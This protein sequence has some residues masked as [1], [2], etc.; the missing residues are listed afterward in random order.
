LESLCV[1]RHL[2]GLR[3]RLVSYV[4]AS[5][6]AKFRALTRDIKKQADSS[7]GTLLVKFLRGSANAPKCSGLELFGSAPPSQPP[8]FNGITTA[9][10]LATLAWQTTPAAVYPVQYQEDLAA[11]NW[12]AFG[13]PLV[14]AGTILSLT[15]TV[16]GLSHRFCH[17]AQIH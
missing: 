9:N 14:A 17:L 1:S 4:L 10:D 16:S 3:F 7:S 15:N 2:A 5:A 8:Q 6:G 13:N 12:L 11:T